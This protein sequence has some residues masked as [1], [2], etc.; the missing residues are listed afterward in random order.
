MGAEIKKV[1]F[2]SEDA[3]G[4]VPTLATP[5]ARGWTL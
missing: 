3:L 1:V 2:P 5:A 4:G